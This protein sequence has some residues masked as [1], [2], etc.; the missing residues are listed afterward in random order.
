M[1]TIIYLDNASTTPTDKRVIKKMLP[2]FSENFANPATK[3]TSSLSKLV[4]EEV[5]QA[6]LNI[7][8]LLG[9]DPDEIFFTS[10]GTESDNTALKGIAFKHHDRGNEIISIPIEHEAVLKSLETLEGFGF[11]IKFA[12]VDSKGFVDPEE[13]KRLITKKTILVSIMHANNEIGTIEPIEEIGKICRER[14][15]YFH[16]DAVQTVGHIP[17]NV[18]SFNVDLLSL[19]AHKFYGPKGVGAIYVRK[20]VKVKPFMDGGGQEKGIRSGTLNTTGIIGLGEAARLASEEMEQTES[21]VKKMRDLLWD[22]IQKQIPK[23]YLNGAEIDSRLSNNLNIIIKGIRN[24]PLLVA[25]NE[26]GVIAG[27]GSACAAGSKYP[28]HVLKSIGV[29]DNDI[30]GAL[31]ITIGKFNK[32][33]YVDYVVQS[34]NEIVNSLRDLSPFWEGE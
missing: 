26:R 22:K 25:L 17:I 28:S 6:R 24:E 32:I 33:E 7:A 18:K 19:S 15:I 20:G 8:K 14:D 3:W 29:K 4:D 23:V 16:T 27:G 1:N 5:E 10:G 9:A 30:F 11:K 2:F 21:D 12:R 31:R 13:I 34:L